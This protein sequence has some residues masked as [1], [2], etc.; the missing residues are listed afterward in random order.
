MIRKATEHDIDAVERGY[1]ELLTHEKDNGSNSNWVLGVYPTRSV[2]EDSCRAGT[3]Y[4]MECDGGICA[5]MILNQVQSEEY[6]GIAW[7]YP[8]R[9]DEVLILH[10]LCI[11]VSYTHLD[12]Y[13]RQRRGSV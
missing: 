4:V 3:L 8:A 5:S 11:P 13:K 12:V 7:E 1:T 6:Y 9:D 2:A 10:T